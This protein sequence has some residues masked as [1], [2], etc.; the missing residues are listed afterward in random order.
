MSNS[1]HAKNESGLMLSNVLH[2]DIGF[3]DTLT[4]LESSAFKM[5]RRMYMLRRV[6]YS[7]ICCTISV[8]IGEL[9]RAVGEWNLEL[10]F[11]DMPQHAVLILGIGVMLVLINY[12]F[13]STLFDRAHQDINLVANIRLQANLM[14]DASKLRLKGYLEYLGVLNNDISDVINQGIYNAPVILEQ[15][16]TAIE[17]ELSSIEGSQL[18]HDLKQIK[19]KYHKN[20]LK[21]LPLSP[22]ITEAVVCLSLLLLFAMSHWLNGDII[23]TLIAV[24]VFLGYLIFNGLWLH[25]MIKSI[26]RVADLNTHLSEIK[27]IGEIVFK[28]SQYTFLKVGFHLGFIFLLYHSYQ[29]GFQTYTDLLWVKVAYVCLMFLCGVALMMTIYFSV[30][31]ANA[32]KKNQKQ[33]P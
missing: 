32:Y 5:A 19:Q 6:I 14:D 18:D 8:F 2:C 31:S 26:N 16:I 23:T 4:E 24:T 3:L 20:L 11:I 12:L 30:C 10:M 1:N 28:P 13:V 9:Y 22:D 17:K 33:N 29:V 27:A 25:H 15:S 21:R 7:L